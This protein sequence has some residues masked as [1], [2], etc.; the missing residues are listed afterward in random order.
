MIEKVFDY[1]QHFVAMMNI[2]NTARLN[3]PK[4]GHKHHIIPKCW[5]RMNNLPIDN[6]KDNLVLLSYEDH[7][8]VHK[9]AYMCALTSKFKGK[10]AYAYLILS[11]G[12][13][14]ANEAFTGEQNSRYGKHMS[15]DTRRKMSEV[16]KRRTGEKNPF[17]GKHHTDDTRMKIS[18]ANKGKTL[19]EETRR[20]MSESLKGK[21]SWLKGKT[22]SEETK[23]KMSEARKGRTF[24][25]EHRRKISEALKGRTWQLVD[26][27]HVWISKEVK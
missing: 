16:A 8:K 17:F 19:S 15:E 21:N 24:T 20:K 22:L 11:S 4:E 3:P 1:N 6:S 9:L 27:K 5:F 12:E 2:I 14:V 10:M 23:K 18:E 26:G 25:E 13:I 7:V